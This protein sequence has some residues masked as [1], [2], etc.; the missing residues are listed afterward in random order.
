MPV[1]GG[2]VHPSHPLPSAAVSIILP[3]DRQT[4]FKMHS[5]IAYSSQPKICQKK[6]KPM[7]IVR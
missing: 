4:V 1:G 3:V 2:G 5:L 6:R 7:V